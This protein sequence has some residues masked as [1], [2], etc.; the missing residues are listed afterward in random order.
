M[1]YITATEK[2]K[3][4]DEAKS[5][6]LLACIGPRGREVYN[7]FVFD[8]DSMKMNFNYIL[9]QF[10]DYCS[11]QQMWLSSDTNSSRIDSQRDN[12]LIT[13]LPNWRSWIRNVNFRIYRIRLSEIWSYW[14]HR[15]SVKATSTPRT[16]FD[17]RLR[18]KTC[19]CI[20]GN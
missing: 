15:Q 9:L 18:S 17:I 11:L 13:L 8:D 1:L 6:V 5:S 16:W 10:V 4:S 2:T 14:Y 19:T 12:V 20:R 3:K 7:M